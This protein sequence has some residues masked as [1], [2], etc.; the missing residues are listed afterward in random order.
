MFL[1]S[2][3]PLRHKSIGMKEKKPLAA[4]IY[5]AGYKTQKQIALAPGITH[6]LVQRICTPAG[7]Q[8]GY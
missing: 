8:A 3:P 1:A 4:D 7:R 5:L 6:F 2:A